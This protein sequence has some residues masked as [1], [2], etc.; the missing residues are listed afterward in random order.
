[1]R[2]ANFEGPALADAP[3]STPAPVWNYYFMVDSIDAAMA[4]TRAAGGTIVMGPQEV[5]GP[6]WVAHCL[7]LD[8]ASFSLVSA[9][10]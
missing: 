7:D 10:P 2:N 9:K 5:P 1:M 4:R 3:P 8:G 6:M